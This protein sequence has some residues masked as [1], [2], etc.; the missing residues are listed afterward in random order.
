MTLMPAPQSGTLFR[1]LFG[2]RPSVQTISDVC[3]KRIC[4]LDTSAFSA[5]GVLDDNCAVSKYTVFQKSDAKIEITITT[6]NLIRIKHPLSNFIC[7]LSGANVANF[8]KIHCTVSEQ[9]LFK[10]GTQ[11]QKFPIWKSRLSSLN[12]LTSV[13]VCALDIF[14]AAAVR[15][16]EA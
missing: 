4:L 8:N 6:S 7:H 10:N 3:F 11:K 14:S 15:K 1:I 12:T 2:T 16:Q 9:Q 5:L 13:T